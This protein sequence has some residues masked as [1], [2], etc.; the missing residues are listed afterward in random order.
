MEVLCQPCPVLCLVKVIH[1]S[2]SC[3][4][5]FAAV[6]VISHAFKTN[7]NS[8]GIDLFWENIFSCTTFAF[9]FLYFIFFFYLYCNTFD[10]SSII[11]FIMHAIEERYA[12]RDRLYYF[13]L[14]SSR[15]LM[16]SFSSLA[17]KSLHNGDYSFKCYYYWYFLELIMTFTQNSVN[18][19]SETSMC[20][21]IYQYDVLCRSSTILLSHLGRLMGQYPII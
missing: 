14:L 4:R 8:V 3:R 6:A 9:V 21:Q 2:S 12:E 13:L 19:L 20:R 10:G 7:H 17:E 1:I 11:I 15:L 18:G 16:V 5:L